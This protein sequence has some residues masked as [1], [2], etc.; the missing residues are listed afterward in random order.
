MIKDIKPLLTWFSL[1]SNDNKAL[2]LMAARDFSTYLYDSDPE[3]YNELDQCLKNYL[4][5]L[6]RR[7]S[8][9]LRGTK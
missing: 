1:L 3:D 7:S 9:A 8:T 5:Q 2:A 4:N 6:E